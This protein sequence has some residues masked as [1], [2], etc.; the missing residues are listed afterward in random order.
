MVAATVC[1]PWPGLQVGP[2]AL[3]AL[4][5]GLFVLGRPRRWQWV[6]WG[7]VAVAAALT[8]RPAVAPRP[9]EE[10][11]TGQLEA[12]C[13]MMV[14]VAR[15]TATDPAVR[16][17]VAMTGEAIDPITPFRALARHVPRG[18]G[19]TV[20][21]A[22]DRGNVVAWAGEETLPP[23]GLWILGERSW[24]VRWSATGAFLALR[25]PILAEGRLAGALLV[26]S[27]APLEGRSAFGM[28]APR[29]WRFRLGSHPGATE[30]APET[31]RQVRVP[32]SVLRGKAAPSAWRWVLWLAVGLLCLLEA[33]AVALAAA[34]L[35][36]FVPDLASA[37]P[38]FLPVAVALLA[39][40]AAARTAVRVSGTVLRGL[41]AAAG[42]L[43]AVDLVL[44]TV[45]ASGTL[46]PGRVA[47]PGRGAVLALAAAW[48]L[49]AFPAVSGRIR[50]SLGRRL[51]A[52]A[53]IALVLAGA[54]AARL[55]FLVTGP[56]AGAGPPL[57]RRA[58]E[59]SA[60]LPAS[61]GQCELED[62]ALALASRW[63]LFRRRTPT[64]VRVLSPAG[65]VVSTWGSLP[66]PGSA[67]R[68]LERWTVSAGDKGPLSVE[69]L[70]AGGPWSWLRDWSPVPGEQA[71][72][73]VLWAVLSRSGDVEATLDPGVRGLDPV[74]AGDLYHRG[75]GW[76]VVPAGWRHLP[77]WVERRDDRLVARILQLPGPAVWAQ[78]A[79]L[80][81]LWAVLGLALA[82]PPRRWFPA[83]GTFGGKLR[84]LVAA[85]IL[86]PLV[87]LTAVVQEGL[88]EEAL[89]RRRESGEATLNA[90]RWT[91]EHLAQGVPI[92]ADLARS[93]ADQTGSEV[94]L[95][96]T[97]FPFASS[98]PDLLQLGLLPP[99]PP[100]EAYARHLLGR[101]DPV[102][103]VRS[104]WV[105]AAA[106]VPA[107]DGRIL[108]TATIADPMN[109]GNLP[110]VA[111]WLLTGAVTA[112]L[113]ALALTGPVEERLDASLRTLIAA[114]RRVQAGE[115]P[116]DLPE[117]A[118]R[119]LAEVVR[120]VQRMS[121][122]VARRETSLRH[123]QELL[124]ITLATVEPAVLVLD[125]AGSIRL[126]NPS[127]EALLAEHR[128]A[129]LGRI[130][131][132]ARI[133]HQRPAAG[134]AIPAGVAFHPATPPATCVEH[135]SATS[136]SKTHTDRPPH[137]LATKVDEKSGVEPDFGVAQPRVATLSPYPGR[138]LTWRL[139]VAPVPLPDG[140]SGLVAV[141]EDVT[142]VVRVD[143]LKQLAQLARIVAHEVKNPLTPVRLWVQEIEAALQRRDESLEKL[144]AEAC[145]EISGQVDRLQATSESF[146]NLVA[147]ERWE[148]V[149]VDVA[150][151]AREVVDSF[152]VLERHG[153][154]LE[155]D[156]PAPGEAV[157]TGDRH[158]ILRALQNLVR[159]SVDAVGEGPGWIAVR[160]RRSA[161]AVTV[162]VEDSGPGVP[163]ERLGELFEP[164]FSTTSGGSGLGLALVRMV[165]GR[166][167]GSVEAS[168]GDAGLRIVLVLPA[169]GNSVR[170]G[171]V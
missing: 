75:S 13:R 45:P 167:G 42:G 145:R 97:P 65:D 10:R 104:G 76:A 86:V 47:A 43:V 44:R 118:E 77:A 32:V 107:G 100:P 11:L 88:R 156:L 124:R 82:L 126:T 72:G 144:V 132:L 64:A 17:V 105:L 140:E 61:P 38:P 96:E 161:E 9:S 89:Q 4:L 69:I 34:G 6:A 87:L 81:L 48:L 164:H 7:A 157:V 71:A 99:L 79:L 53:A 149:P 21:L 56:D 25:E 120:A 36:V 165:V 133:A 19:L 83:A 110:G 62:L 54:E 116:G 125:A 37:V 33:P 131:E 30:L 113:L 29:G 70:G 119:D 12:H 98:R 166:L 26:L 130:A 46:L 68:V 152:R 60:V 92:D 162:T 139:G 159:N 95:S 1:A 67:I 31:V 2:V 94:V 23:R 168:N 138:E 141:V 41:I 84:L 55:P 169:R 73:P 135:A 154:R 90:L 163:E 106:S 74:T 109:H 16:R 39:A 28:N 146:S 51:L 103:R 27:R 129:V 111:D 24:F 102:L 136:W 5:A 142:E 153:I 134:E 22:D 117:P 66:L 40:G 58:P 123:Q 112:A 57:P 3:L 128:E 85:G 18:A 122:E 115:P 137:A 114:A 148:A 8:L 150:E 20:F 155:A 101:D 170:V 63:E 91:L 151:A 147:L 52:G 93:L 78:R 15:E 108:V 14:S 49:A 160:V 171:N 50:Q 121:E 127:A 59:M 143:R 35:L 80:A 158:W